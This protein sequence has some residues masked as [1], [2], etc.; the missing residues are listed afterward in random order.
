MPKLQPHY[1]IGSANLK[2]AITIILGEYSI[3]NSSYSEGRV[4]RSFI[5]FAN[6]VYKQ[7]K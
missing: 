7:E 4:R 2:I 3:T 5:L 6:T 1:S